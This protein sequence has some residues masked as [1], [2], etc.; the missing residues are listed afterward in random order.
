MLE[1]I[2]HS[3]SETK[4]IAKSIASHLETGDIIILSGDL[5]SR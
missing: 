4:N 2:S 5:G 3:E 1:L